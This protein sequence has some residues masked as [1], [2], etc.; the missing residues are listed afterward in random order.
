MTASIA[1]S[2]AELQ[3]WDSWWDALRVV[4]GRDHGL[5]G[6]N[7][8]GCLVLACVASFILAAIWMTQCALNIFMLCRVCTCDVAE[9]KRKE[10]RT[11]LIAQRR[12]RLATPSVTPGGGA[13][14]HTPVTMQPLGPSQ[15]TQT[16]VPRQYG[17]PPPQ[18]QQAR[19]EPFPEYGKQY[20]TP[21]GKMT[22]P[23]KMPLDSASDITD[24]G[25]AAAVSPQQ[26]HMLPPPQR[27]M[28]PSP[29]RPAAEGPV[30]ASPDTSASPPSYHQLPALQARSPPSR[31]V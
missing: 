23:E 1:A 25:A 31:L 13:G 24:H 9:E 8:Y 20:Y 27:R 14:R 4:R 5:Y 11:V 15:P 26:H 3:S 17:Q 29:K 16:G 2:C 19:Q 18:Q 28:E 12:S 21:P 10:D 7:F 6:A 22:P 30:V